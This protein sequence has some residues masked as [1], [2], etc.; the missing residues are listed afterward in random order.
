MHMNKPIFIIGCPRSGTTLLA[1]LVSAT[2]YGAPVETHFITKYFKMLDSYGDLSVKKNFSLLLNDIL[3]ERPVMQWKLDSDVDRFYDELDSFR[4]EHIADRICMKMAEKK[5]YGAWGDK[6]PHYIKDLDIIYKLFPESK[7]IYIIRD[8]RDVALSLLERE[9]GPANIYDCAQIW[10]AHNV[11]SATLEKIESNGQLYTLKYEDLLDNAEEIV[12]GIYKFL[13]VEYDK[14]E[15]T[16]LLRTIKK[17][18]YNK[19]KKRMSPGQIKVFENVAADTL[20]RFGYET[21]NEESEI[22][23][24]MKA[25]YSC[26]KIIMRAKFL[27]KTNVIDGIKIRYFGK[28]PFAE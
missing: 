8:G 4:Y 13:D 28:E 15:V 12:L 22:D 14:K 20:K 2:V 25:A 23:G 3:A 18:N 6:T 26:H 27:F 7:Y 1:S 19:W 16:R 11:K 17:G 5:G 10:K 24:L 21:S 9:W